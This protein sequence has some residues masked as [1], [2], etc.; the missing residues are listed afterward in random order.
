MTPELAFA[1]R[2]REDRACG[3]GIER[4]GGGADRR[5]DLITGDPDQIDEG[6]FSDKPHRVIGRIAFAVELPAMYF[7]TRDGRTPAWA[8]R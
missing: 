1:R 2:R 6:T 4:G 7:S 8:R 5:W 3:R